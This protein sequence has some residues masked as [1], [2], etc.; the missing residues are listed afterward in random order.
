MSRYPVMSQRPA[1]YDESLLVG[2][3]A[4]SRQDRQAGYDIN[5][6]EQGSYASPVAAYS[7][8]PQGVGA[9]S[10]S[11]YNKPSAPAAVDAN[12][13]T[14]EEDER[15]R[16]PSLIPPPKK[17]WWKTKRGRWS[18]FFGLIVFIG[19]IAG[20]AAGAGAA[21]DSRNQTLLS[22]NNENA[23]AS[24]PEANANPSSSLS[25]TPSPTPSSASN[26]STSS[27]SNNLPPATITATAGNGIPSGEPV[28]IGIGTTLTF[29]SPVATSVPVPPNQPSPPSQAPGSSGNEPV[30]SDGIPL[31]CYIVPSS[32]ECAP[33]FEN[34]PP[35]K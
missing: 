4:L 29:G 14:D 1:A 20:I 21:R 35:R 18:L 33:Y 3:P 12:P 24:S 2:A 8:N 13:F 27:T 10:T 7:Y 31:I 22:N 34:D 17:P 26:P 19:I 28:V 30:S 23:A 9:T 25:R 11:Q 15:E 6:L 32:S 5:A 16:T